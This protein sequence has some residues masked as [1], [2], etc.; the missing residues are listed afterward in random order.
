MPQSLLNRMSV[1]WAWECADCWWIGL[2]W[3]L[4]SQV[5]LGDMWPCFPQK[6]NGVHLAS[7][8]SSCYLLGCLRGG[9]IHG[10]AVRNG[11]G[12][13]VGLSLVQAI[14]FS[15]NMAKLVRNTMLVNS[16][17]VIRRARQTWF[18]NPWVYWLI[19]IWVSH[20]VVWEWMLNLY[21]YMAVNLVY[22]G[23]W[24]AFLPFVFFS[25]SEKNCLKILHTL[26][27]LDTNT[28]KQF[29]SYW[30]G[31][32]TCCSSKLKKD[33]DKF[34]V[35]FGKHVYFGNGIQSKMDGKDLCLPNMVC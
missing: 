2:I 31:P 13:M 8:A 25:V 27:M 17:H 32:A 19:N 34:A 28:R 20:V 18:F 12:S 10:I 21:V 22:L 11:G 15:E 7:S 26:G 29:S 6:N 5:I 35:V 24:M 4:N 3:P 30:L 23:A 1:H 33:K 16:T 14:V 9:D